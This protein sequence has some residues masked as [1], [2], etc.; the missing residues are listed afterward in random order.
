MKSRFIYNNQLTIC[1]ASPALIKKSWGSLFFLRNTLAMFFVVLTAVSAGAFVSVSPSVV[2]LN[3]HPATANS[4]NLIV[5]N[6][7]SE[8]KIISIEIKE[9]WNAQ[10]GLSGLSPE[11]WL[12][13]KPSRPFK[14]GAGKSRP[15]K[16]RVLMP[17][18][19]Q[20]E[21]AAMVFFSINSPSE[22][23]QHLNFELR[24]GIPIY[25]IAENTGETAIAMKDFS[26]YFVPSSTSSIECAITIINN[27]TIHVRPSGK[28]KFYKENILIETDDLEY[29]WPVYPNRDHIFHAHTSSLNWIP[30]DYKVHTEITVG[31]PVQNKIQ[32][33]GFNLS[34]E[35]KITIK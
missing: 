26:A 6:P 22:G 21:A 34:N 5:T 16:Y 19:Y 27:G 18:G 14:L 9:W 28:I 30:G 31:S 32:E 15:V 12:L 29:G 13:L 33:Y 17:A 4:G 20:G 23:Q 24:H 25:V 3:V 10:T 1:K 11:K 35:G 2:E 8:S 7:T